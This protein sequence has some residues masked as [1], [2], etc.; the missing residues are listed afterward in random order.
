MDLTETVPPIT[1]TATASDMRLT[2]CVSLAPALLAPMSD[3]L[4]WHTDQTLRGEG[5][6]YVRPALGEEARIVPLPP[7]FTYTGGAFGDNVT[8]SDTVTLTVDELD[9]SIEILLGFPDDPFL[10][11]QPY[12]AESYY[13]HEDVVG[14]SMQTFEGYDREPESG[15]PSMNFD[16]TCLPT[17]GMT[18]LAGNT[19]AFLTSIGGSCSNAQHDVNVELSSEGMSGSITLSSDLYAQ[20]PW[21]GYPINCKAKT[22]TYLDPRS[23]VLKIENNANAD[24]ELVLDFELV[25]EVLPPDEGTHWNANGYFN[26]AVSPS[27]CDTG[28]GFVLFYKEGDDF[29]GTGSQTVTL[30]PGTHY[31]SLLILWSIRAESQNGDAEYSPD[32]TRVEARADGTISF[33]IQQ[34]TN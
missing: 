11:R 20:Y 28:Y 30:S 22:N 13:Y 25:G 5:G 8:N 21:G 6:V 7:G 17:G 27:V 31:V 34:Q 2:E 33:R 32:N 29:N 14:N 26:I 4:N 9:V 19:Q 15:L 24:V 18:I 23:F 3:Q 16:D 12:M 1:W 10:E